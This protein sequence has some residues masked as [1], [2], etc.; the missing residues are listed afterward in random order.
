MDPRTRGLGT[1]HV[2]PD[3]IFSERILAQLSDLV[4]IYFEF[5]N[6]KDML[7]QNII[8]SEK[9]FYFINKRI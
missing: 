3:D 1:L 6:K 2:I 8:L 7:Q 9:F 4:F 5:F